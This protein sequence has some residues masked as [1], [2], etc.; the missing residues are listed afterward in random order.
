MHKARLRERMNETDPTRSPSDDDAQAA[1]P[2]PP[3]GQGENYP[4]LHP[5]R[6]TWA[7]LLGQWVDLAK[8]AL[9]LGN[10]PASAA[11]KKLVPDIIMLQALWHALEDMAELPLEEQKLGCLRAQWLLD[12]HHQQ[13]LATWPSTEPLPQGLQDLIHDASAALD[14][15]QKRLAI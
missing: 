6:L 4:P 5:E 8:S 11:L 13:I 9:A 2:V 10:D 7:V 15:A 14:R 1:S 12:K 3:E